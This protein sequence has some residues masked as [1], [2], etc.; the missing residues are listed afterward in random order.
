MACAEGEEFKD[1]Q[2]AMELD[3]VVFAYPAAPGEWLN[4]SF[5]LFLSSKRRLLLGY[6]QTQADA[7]LSLHMS[8]VQIFLCSTLSP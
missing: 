6:Q 1:V 7:S 5:F 4:V 8:I 3:D 2:G